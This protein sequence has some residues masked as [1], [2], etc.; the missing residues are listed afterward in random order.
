MIR[1]VRSEVLHGTANI[2]TK[3]PPTIAISKIAIKVALD[4]DF[5]V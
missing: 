5:F 3:H 2:A 1:K 4:I